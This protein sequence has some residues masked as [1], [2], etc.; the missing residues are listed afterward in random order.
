MFPLLLIHFW[1]VHIEYYEICISYSKM[2]PQFMADLLK[3][4]NGPNFLNEMQ[5]NQ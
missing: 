2:S 1:K 3:K 5:W 4:K